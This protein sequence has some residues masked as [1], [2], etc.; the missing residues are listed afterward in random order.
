MG[1][2]SPFTEAITAAFWVLQWQEDGVHSWS[3]DLILTIVPY[4]TTHTFYLPR[5]PGKLDHWLFFRRI[6]DIFLDVFPNF[7]LMFS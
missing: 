3:Q 7:Q 5:T 1:G 2:R 4:L 6:Q